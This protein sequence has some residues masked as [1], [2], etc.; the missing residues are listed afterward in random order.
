MAQLYIQCYSVELPNLNYTSTSHSVCWRGAKGNRHWE[1][2]NRL[3][4]S[5]IFET[6]LDKVD[7]I[8]LRLLE[9]DGLIRIHPTGQETDCH[10][11][12][13]CSK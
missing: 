7:P 10:L 3:S 5:T 9:K 2:L 1:K 6:Q 13:V 11:P 8:Y 4:H 12:D